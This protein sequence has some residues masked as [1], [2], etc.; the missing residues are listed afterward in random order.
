MHRAHDPNRKPLTTL[1]G[2]SPHDGAMGARPAAH[3]ARPVPPARGEFNTLPGGLGRRKPAP[4]RVLDSND[5]IELEPM[6]MMPLHTQGVFSMSMPPR[7]APG[8]DR[9]RRHTPMKSAAKL[10][11]A[12]QLSA[13]RMGHRILGAMFALIVIEI[14]IL[15]V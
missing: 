7:H 8:R 1:L 15:V 13:Q 5:V 12:A 10:S 6:S 14:L 3:H 2:L 9:P 4:I 11:S